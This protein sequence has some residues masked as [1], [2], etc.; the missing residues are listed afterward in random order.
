MAS[1]SPGYVFPRL[2]GFFKEDRKVRFEKLD[3]HAE[4]IAPVD[5][6]GW[7]IEINRRRE[8]VNELPKQYLSTHAG[9]HPRQGQCV[10]I[11]LRRAPW[12]V[13]TY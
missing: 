5:I 2:S 3:S 11:F 8:S 4:L 13:K 7:P 12:I 1:A 9:T 10:S 6:G